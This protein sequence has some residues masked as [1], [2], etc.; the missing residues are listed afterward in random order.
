MKKVWILEGLVTPDK[1]KKSIAE[2]EGW[3]QEMIATNNSD[4]VEAC[5]RTIANLKKKLELF[6]N[7]Y[8]LGYDGKIIYSQFCDCAKRT[9]K[10]MK[11]KM[12][13]RVVKAEIED[14]AKVW[15]DYMNPVENEGVLR[16]LMATLYR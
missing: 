1:T 12:Q 9:L 4:G 16:Y 8:W 10:N 14:D 3:K 6:P 7:G 11:D 2:V 13:F 5:E 15:T